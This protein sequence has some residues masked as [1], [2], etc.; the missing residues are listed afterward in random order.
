LIEVF[1]DIQDVRIRSFN[2]LR[3]VG[4][5]EGVN[6]KHLKLLEKEIKDYI[7]VSIR[8]IPIRVKF[9]STVKGIGAILGGGLIAYLDPHKADHA[10]SFWKYCGLH[11]ENGKAVKRQKGVKLGFNV[12]LR[13]LMWKIADSFVKQRTPFYR[14]VYD[15]TKESEN[16]KLGNPIKNPKNCPMYAECS[17]RLTTT[18]KRKGTT[19]KKM[20]CKKHIDYRARRKMVKRFLADLWG[21]W[22]ALEGL[23]VTEPYSHRNEP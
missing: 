5:V 14:D 22:R 11:V 20:P 9:L 18:A 12:H 17:Q 8:D 21:A 10:S 6:P 1:Y 13:T 15:N 23:P 2:R 3:Q 7:E 19:K 16:I 4:E